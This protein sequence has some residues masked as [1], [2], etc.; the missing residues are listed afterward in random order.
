MS[1]PVKPTVNK[2]M[3]NEEKLNTICF[4]LIKTANEKNVEEFK[5]QQKKVIHMDEELGDWE[6]IV[7]KIPK[8]EI[9]VV[10]SL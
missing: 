5:I 8:N 6:I 10:R 4:F 3:S 9:V 1:D 7:R 2:P